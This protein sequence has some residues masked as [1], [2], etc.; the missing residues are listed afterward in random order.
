LENKN[1]IEVLMFLISKLT[2]QHG[3]CIQMDTYANEIEY[4]ELRSKPSQV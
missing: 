3:A 1:K 4:T 2:M